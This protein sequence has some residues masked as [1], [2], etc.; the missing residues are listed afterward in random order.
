M[1]EDCDMLDCGTNGSADDTQT[2]CICDDGWQGRH[3]DK[4]ADSLI[5][6]TDAPTTTTQIPFIIITNPAATT[7]TVI[8]TNACDGAPCKNR[9]K[10]KDLPDW[11]DSELGFKCDCDKTGYTGP[12][13]EDKIDYCLDQV[14]TCG[15]GTCVSTL[16]TYFCE[17]PDA[18]GTE[19]KKDGKAK[20]CNIDKFC[21]SKPCENGLECADG[22][23]IC[24]DLPDFRPTGQWCEEKDY[25]FK[26]GTAVTC[27]GHGDCIN[28][29][30]FNDYICR[31]EL[32]WEGDNCETMIEIETTTPIDIKPKTQTPIVI[33]QTTTPSAV[34]GTTT[35]I[36]TT[37]TTTTPT[38]TTT[39]STT[40]TTT[41]ANTT[42]TSTT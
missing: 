18:W 27:N 35:T 13:C 26:N 36:A 4:P 3:C 33:E 20:D 40:T 14:D 38:N 24:I 8:D 39:T 6:P 15:K 2:S 37:P 31:C 23:C 19:Q 1:G 34:T 25:C 30:G 21:K 9:G 5:I 16:L 41:P 12:T 11:K 42:T 32:G 17:C 7:G 29:A 28:E 10:C 22:A